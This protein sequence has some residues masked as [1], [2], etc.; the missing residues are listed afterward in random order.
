MASSYQ[1]KNYPDNALPL[2]RLY[3]MDVN[4]LMIQRVLSEKRW[5]NRM[6]AT[7]LR[8]LPPLIYGHVNPYRRFGLDMS[9]RL[10]IEA[11][12]ALAA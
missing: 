2:L 12:L 1:I 5:R 4:T 11:D 3:L 9:K 8:A 10:S 6:N 7:D